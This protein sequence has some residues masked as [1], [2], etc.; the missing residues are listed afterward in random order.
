MSVETK[1]S[2]AAARLG[3]KGKEGAQA[4]GREAARK[5]PGG[6]RE[7]ITQGPCMRMTAVAPSQR[8]RAAGAQLAAM[9]HAH[10][11]AVSALR[12][13]KAVNSPPG[14]VR[15]QGMPPHMGMRHG[16]QSNGSFQSTRH[17]TRASQS[18]H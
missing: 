8:P 7:P 15:G 3:Q 5:P 10:A 4:R 9:S 18:A 14:G 6:T 12:A 17:T 11:G 13:G 2:R 1:T 16:A